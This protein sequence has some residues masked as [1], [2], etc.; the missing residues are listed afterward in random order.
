MQQSRTKLK[1]QIYNKDWSCAINQKLL[2]KD[3]KKYIDML[4][5]EKSNL[6]DGLIIEQQKVKKY[7][8]EVK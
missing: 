8:V 3:H 6:D 5:T 1:D 4:C 7:L 2:I